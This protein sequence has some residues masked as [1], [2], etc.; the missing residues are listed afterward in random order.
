MQLKSN[1]FYTTIELFQ[2]NN[3][4]KEK[5]NDI[6]SKTTFP[7]CQECKREY[8]NT[9]TAI[10]VWY[11]HTILCLHS[12]FS[13]FP[14]LL[15]AFVVPT[16]LFLFLLQIQTKRMI[17]YLIRWKGNRA[18]SDNYCS[19]ECHHHNTNYNFYLYKCIIFEFHFER[20][21]FHF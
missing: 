12:E 18:D 5:K 21:G 11:I 19:A 2:N 8:L 4:E 9:V 16:R 1:L 15:L 17:L 20:T 10:S 14:L 6:K 3:R 13:P 7:V